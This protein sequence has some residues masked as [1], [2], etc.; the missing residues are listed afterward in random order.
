MCY[1]GA[2]CQSPWMDE[3]NVE[4]Q[5]RKHDH[6]QPLKITLREV[7]PGLKQSCLRG[8]EGADFT[9]LLE[10]LWIHSAGRKCCVP[11]GT[12]CGH[13]RWERQLPQRTPDCGTKQSWSHT[14]PKAP[15]DSNSNT[16]PKVYHSVPGYLTRLALGKLDSSYDTSWGPIGPMSAHGST[17][18]PTSVALCLPRLGVWEKPEISR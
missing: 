13:R 15:Q 1:W 9:F 2:T 10:G 17:V 4:E 11:A 3:A 6:T 12:L 18:F 8:R 7:W 14:G 16:D 5:Q